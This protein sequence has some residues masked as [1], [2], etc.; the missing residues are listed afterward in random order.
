MKV[1]QKTRNDFEPVM[2]SR[3]Q[4]VALIEQAAQRR[5]H[6]SAQD[7]LRQ[8]RTGKLEDPGRVA[9]LL[10]LSKLLPDNDPIFGNVPA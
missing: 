1:N 8:Y 2:L 3:Q 7:L 10:A 9:D 5:L 4:I 6:R